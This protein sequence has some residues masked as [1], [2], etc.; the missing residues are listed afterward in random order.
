MRR[1]LLVLAIGLTGCATAHKDAL[2]GRPDSGIVTI[3]DSN[4]NNGDSG[5]LIDAAPHIDS[6]MGGGTQTLSQ[7]TANNDTAVGIACAPTAG[8]WTDRNSYYRVFQLSNYGINGTFHVTGIDFIVSA[9]AKSP[10]LNIGIGTYNG[11]TG[12][13]T[14]NSAGITLTQTTTFTPSDTQTA[15]PQHIDIAA[16]ITGNLIVEID[17]GT[18]GTSTNPLLFYVGANEAGESVPGYISSADCS[19]PTPTSMDT[20]AQGQMTPTHADMVLTVTGST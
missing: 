3:G 20:E 17:Q 9:A 10:T 19:L 7:T 13:Q 12:G 16:D 4:N 15:V 8:G 14:L 5:V 11:T 2:G 18:A 6:M 1:K